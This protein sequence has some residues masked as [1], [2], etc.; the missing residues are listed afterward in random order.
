MTVT[1]LTA[2]SEEY[3]PLLELGASNKLEYC[4]RHKVQFHMVKHNSSVT[5]AWGERELFMLDALNTYN[6]DWL[7]FMGAD[8]LITNMKKDIRELCDD[9]F[10]FIIG[11]DINGINNDSILLKNN[12]KTKRFLKRVI[13]RRDCGDD[14]HAMFMECKQGL[15]TGLVPQRNF[16]S[17][18]YDEYH[19]GAYPE[20]AWQEGDFVLHLPG[21]SMQRRLQLMNEFLP[22]VRR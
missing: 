9:G 6:T 10:D 1:L 14:Q 12:E 2:A 7:W 11:V 21:L 5:N 19:Y 17:Y 16:N 18:K 8:T 13:Y 4:L 15:E 3:W 22:K 20:G